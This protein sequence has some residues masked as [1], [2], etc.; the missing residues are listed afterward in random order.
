M[1]T[2]TDLLIKEFHQWNNRKVI[3]IQELQEAE[4]FY[5]Q[6]EE[7]LIEE[8]FYQCDDD[9]EK[10]DHL[11]MLKA[12]LPFANFVLTHPLLEKFSKTILNAEEHFEPDGPPISGVT[13]QFFYYWLLFD[14]RVTENDGSIASIYLKFHENALETSHD[15]IKLIKMFINSRLGIYK[16]TKKTNY[17]IYLKELITD[18]IVTTSSHYCREAQIDEIWLARLVPS[19]YDYNTYIVTMTPYILVRNTE[20]EWLQ[21]FERQGI[22]KETLD[23]EKLA[24]LMKNGKKFDYW[25]DYV[26]YAYLDDDIDKIYLQGIPDI[27][28]SFPDEFDRYEGYDECDDDYDDDDDDDDHDYDDDDDHDYDDDDDDDD[29]YDDDD[30]DDDDDDYY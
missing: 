26:F 24:K 10:L 14:M 27:V 18:K 16:V 4:N 6:G 22:T 5:S 9:D 13:V 29:D 17:E 3:N 8:Q 2:I 11:L 7:Y 21:F 1:D 25:L 30:D 15:I 19:L 23:E 20:F 28:S 12:I